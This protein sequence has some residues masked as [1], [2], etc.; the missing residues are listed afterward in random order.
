MR[1]DPNTELNLATPKL[2]L[3][4]PLEPVLEFNSLLKEEASKGRARPGGR[5]GAH[6]P[7]PLAPDHPLAQT[8]GQ[9][10]AA[11]DRALR[12]PT[13]SFDQRAPV[14]RAMAARIPSA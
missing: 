6:Q 2:I 9:A 7:E 3:I 12:R 5:A 4:T 8:G 11:G 14:A 13:S 1:R 10:G